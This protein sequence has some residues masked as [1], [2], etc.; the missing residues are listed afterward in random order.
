MNLQTYK[1]LHCNVSTA[2][3]VRKNNSDMIIL[4][5][6]END[7]Q[8]R[9]CYI[10]DYYHDKE[11][12][13]TPVDAK[14]IV[15]QYSTLSKDQVE[16]HILFKP[17]SG[18]A[19]D[20]YKFYQEKYNAE[21]PVGLYID[22]PDADGNYQKWLICASDKEPQF[23]KHS[24][25]PCNYEFKWIHNGEKHSMWGVAR[26]RNSYNSGLWTDYSTTLVENQDQIWLPMND[27]SAQIYYGKR[28]IVS[29]LI[30]KPI[31]WQISKVENFHPFGINKL[32]LY[33]DKFNV[34]TDYVNFE[35]GEMYADYYE[36]IVEPEEY[37]QSKDTYLTTINVTG[38]DYK[39]RVPHYTKT[40]SVDIDDVSIYTPIY[41]RITCDNGDLIELFNIEH[42]GDYSEIL[43]L[44]TD[45]F[46]TVG[47]VIE[48]AAFSDD[49][50]KLTDTVKLEVVSF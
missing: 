1:R 13:K 28:L 27:I 6:W 15:T 10:Y 35:T 38:S 31:T 33:Q 22:I 46:E 36:S 34:K 3:Q 17:R 14:Y 8:S 32:T 12:E 5:T 29:A 23:V 21:Y 7:I 39:I 45:D 2:G 24:I 11:G 44:S 26:M 16:Y 37:A 9:K 50:I 43:C 40:L 42:S 4:N 48:V 18:C 20:Y 41:W 25:L 19:V 49:G 30:E 47:S